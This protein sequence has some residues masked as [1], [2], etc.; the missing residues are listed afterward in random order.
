M[1]NKKGFTLIEMLVVVLIIGIL[2]GVAL[3]Q[4]ERAVEKA[5]TAEP[6][7]ILKDMFRAQQECGLK[8]ELWKCMG[9]NFWEN[10]SF[11]PPTELVDVC[12]DTAPCFKTKYWEYFADDYLYAGRVKNNEMIAILKLGLYGNNQSIM[13]AVCENW[14]EE[15]YCKTIGM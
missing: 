15:D 8:N 3:P 4:Y 12:V 11:D 13:S 9:N 10:A 7:I 14:G 5:R 6:K 1:K 2:A